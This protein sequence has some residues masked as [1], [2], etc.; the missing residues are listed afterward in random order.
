LPWWLYKLHPK[1]KVKEINFQNRYIYHL[2]LITLQLS[3]PKIRFINFM[4]FNTV[5]KQWS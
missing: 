3:A 5:A 2:Y 1:I 4:N